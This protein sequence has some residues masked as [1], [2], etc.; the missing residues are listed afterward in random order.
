MI[1]SLT[2]T[3]QG[4]WLGERGLWPSLLS[5]QDGVSFLLGAVHIV[6]EIPASYTRRCTGDGEGHAV[7]T[8]AMPLLDHMVVV[9]ERLVEALTCVGSIRMGLCK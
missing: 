5:L 2:V 7:V 3:M 6:L 1:N 8:G 4:T 9:E